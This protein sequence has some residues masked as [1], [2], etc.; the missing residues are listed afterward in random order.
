[1][2]AGAD[3]MADLVYTALCSLDGY[4]NDAAG[5]FAWAAPDA[6]VHAFVN[7]LER[8]S[9]THLYGRRTYDVMRVWDDMDDDDPIMRDFAQIWHCAD[10][11]V[12]SRTLDSAGPRTRIA[13]TF[14]PEEVARL[15]A[16]ATQSL[17]IGGAHLA[18]SAFQAGLVD[19]VRLLVAPVVVGA[20][21]PVFLL[22]TELEL[23]DHRTFAS[24]FVFLGYRVSSHQTVHNPAD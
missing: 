8:P 1:V 13:R 18:A 15:K 16:S 20:G 10:K 24:G 21:T 5:G 3:L 9:A 2:V 12:Y 23:T 4:V 11:I 14:D 19:V 22:P 7:D 6:Q 17:S